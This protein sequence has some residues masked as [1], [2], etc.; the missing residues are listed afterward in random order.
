METSIFWNI[1][2]LRVRWEY[3]FLFFKRFIG[4]VIWVREVCVFFRKLGFVFYLRF[5]VVKVGGYIFRGI[6]I[7]NVG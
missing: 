4:D 7:Y 3:G 5:F 6:R 1:S 2:I